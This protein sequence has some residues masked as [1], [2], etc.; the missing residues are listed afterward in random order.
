MASRLIAAAAIFMA[1]AILVF[2]PVDNAIKQ[3]LSP[4]ARRVR[5]LKAQNPV[6]VEHHLHGN[7]IFKFHYG[8][9]L[10]DHSAC[11]FSDTDRLFPRNFPRNAHFFF[12]WKIFFV[13]FSQI[14]ENIYSKDSSHACINR[15]AMFA[16]HECIYTCHTSSS[17]RRTLRSSLALFHSSSLYDYSI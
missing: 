11:A 8:T 14:S 17:S 1:L 7:Q 4:E 2:G 6:Q 9:V 16:L 12:F 5:D 13:N 3:T 10:H 15:S